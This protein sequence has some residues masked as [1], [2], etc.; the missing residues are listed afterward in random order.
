[1]ARGCRD[2]TNASSAQVL[3]EERVDVLDLWQEDM[4]AFLL[5]CSFTWEDLDW[6]RALRTSSLRRSCAPGTWRRGAT[7]P[8]STP[9]S[10]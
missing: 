6:Y 7:C 10:G 3:T 9:A 5:G 8:C 1:M 4:Q 2:L